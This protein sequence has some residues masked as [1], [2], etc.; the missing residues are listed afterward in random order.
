MKKLQ[1]R[2]ASGSPAASRAVRVGQV[3]SYL[4]LSQY[5]PEAWLFFFHGRYDFAWQGLYP[6]GTRAKPPYHRGMIAFSDRLAASLRRGVLAWPADLFSNR[7]SG[8]ARKAV[9]R[10]FRKRPYRATKSANRHVFS[11]AHF[12]PQTLQFLHITAGARRVPRARA[13]AE[14]LRVRFA[15]AWSG[16]VRE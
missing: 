5:F 12:R 2:H 11:F 15:I 3:R 6:F 13:E 16:R 4:R 9:L 10:I 7:A 8:H 14:W 1:P